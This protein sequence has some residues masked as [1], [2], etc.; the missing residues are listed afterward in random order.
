LGFN[1]ANHYKKRSIIALHQTASSS[2][3]GSHHPLYLRRLRSFMRL[4]QSYAFIS[5]TPVSPNTG[6]HRG[7]TS[8]VGRVLIRD[9]GADML[10]L[11]VHCTV[12]VLATPLRFGSYITITCRTGATI[13]PR[14]RQWLAWRP[15]ESCADVR[16]LGLASRGVNRLCSARCRPQQQSDRSKKPHSVYPNRTPKTSCTVKLAITQSL[17]DPGCW[18]SMLTMLTGTSRRCPS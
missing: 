14:H 12:V 5:T 6:L 11:R 3:Q 15:P 7:R 10:T 9:H 13:R 17:Y 1:H 16:C 2:W 8:F 4:E 18:V